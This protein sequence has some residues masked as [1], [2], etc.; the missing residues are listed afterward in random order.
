MCQEH[1]EGNGMAA[2]DGVTSTTNRP[3]TGRYDATGMCSEEIK[4]VS[5]KRGRNGGPKTQ[6]KTLKLKAGNGRDSA[7]SD[8]GA[9]AV[10]LHSQPQDTDWDKKLRK[11]VK[12][13]TGGGIGGKSHS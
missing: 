2:G 6:S 4:R 13:S 9:V 5:V 3:L 11:R 12:G 1:F 8:Y 7:N 10:G